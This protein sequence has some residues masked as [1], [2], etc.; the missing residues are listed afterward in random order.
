MER[1]QPPKSEIFATGAFERPSCILVVDDNAKFREVVVAVLENEGHSVLEAGTAEQA[2]ELARHEEP[3]LLILDIHLP[4]MDGTRLCKAIKEDE[5]LKLTPILLITGMQSQETHLIALDCGANDYLRKPFDNRVLAARVRLLLKYRHAIRDLVSARDEMERNVTLRTRQLQEANDKLRK[6]V[7]SHRM[8]LAELRG[9]NRNIG[10]LIASIPSLLI[11]VN[12]HLV[13]QRMN[14]VAERVLGVRASSCVG[15]ILTDSGISWDVE[16]LAK[17]LSQNEVTLPNPCPVEVSFTKPDGQDGLLGLAVTP[18]S[19]EEGRQIGHLIIGADITEKR[20]LE[21]ALREKTEMLQHAQRM[22]AVGQ[23][24]GGIAHE[25][26]NLM[27]VVLGYSKRILAK[28]DPDWPLRSEL[29][30]IRTAGKR[31]ADITR[32]LLLYSRKDKVEPEV[33]RLNEL[34]LGCHALLRPLICENIKLEYDLDAEPMY[35]HADK[36]LIEQVVVNLVVNARDAMPKGGK[37]VIGCKPVSQGRD[38][39][40]HDCPNGDYLLLSVADTG[41]GMSAS[42]RERIFEPF[43][44]T[45]GPGKGTGLG[46]ATV[47]GIVKQAG[48]SIRVESIPDEG[49]RF[50]I[51]LPRSAAE[52]NDCLPKVSTCC[53]PAVG[54]G[55]VLLVEDENGVRNLLQSVLTEG[56]FEVLA[57]PDPREALEYLQLLSEGPQLV[58][59]DVVMPYMSGPELA[60]RLKLEWPASKFL[61]MSGYP[62]TIEDLDDNPL[63]KEPF[64]PKPI[65]PAVLLRTVAEILSSSSPIQS[66]GPSPAPARAANIGRAT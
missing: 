46:L 45:K 6:E 54:K 47:Y 20:K 16:D 9:L 15:R 61:F 3:D 13:I 4:G 31:A 1:A 51:L 18:V 48:G 27:T 21:N 41:C 63:A 62:A 29:M 7:D 33:M 23:L 50:E 40:R 22:E 42:I 8:T 35:V 53:L 39:S 28:A 24:A 38:D 56:G 37:I 65:E 66:S 49:T 10:Q 36:R 57:A 44:T 17:L 32:Q 11:R 55:T 12:E 34:L 14:G 30:E 2:I 43:F 58:I 26:N 64:L 60:K 25:F 52:G 19:D 5:Q 59:L